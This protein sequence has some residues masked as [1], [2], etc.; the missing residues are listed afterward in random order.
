M[1]KSERQK[2][3]SAI[4]RTDEISSPFVVPLSGADL[5]TSSATLSLGSDRP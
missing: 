1:S 4:Y 2:L 5:P 3:L